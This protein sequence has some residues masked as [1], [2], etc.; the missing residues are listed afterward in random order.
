[1]LTKIDVRSEKSKLQVIKN[2]KKSLF[3]TRIFQ[4]IS[5]RTEQRKKY[6]SLQLTAN[7]I[8][9]PWCLRHYIKLIWESPTT[10]DAISTVTNAPFIQNSD[11]TAPWV[12]CNRKFSERIVSISAIFKATSMLFGS[13]GSCSDDKNWLDFPAFSLRFVDFAVQFCFRLSFR[14]HSAKSNRSI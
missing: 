10:K 9:A 13:R 7:C 5:D 4:S 1:M 6:S 3:S 14:F 2:E 12:D 11:R 8:A